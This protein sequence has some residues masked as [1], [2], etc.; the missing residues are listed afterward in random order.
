[1]NVIVI[2]K[3]VRKRKITASLKAAELPEGRGLK[4][5]DR[6]L[7]VPARGSCAISGLCPGDIAGRFGVAGLGT[8]GFG[9]GPLLLWCGIELKLLTQQGI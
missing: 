9:V 5:P 4:V 2:V 6:G 1:M 7:S 3:P 8:G